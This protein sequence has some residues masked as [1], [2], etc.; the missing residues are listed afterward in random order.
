MEPF[1]SLK[2]PLSSR[3]SSRIQLD[4]GKLPI[5]EFSPYVIR[6]VGGRFPILDAGNFEALAVNLSAHL[7][8]MDLRST[9]IPGFDSCSKD[10]PSVLLRPRWERLAESG[11]MGTGSSV[12][13]LMQSL[14]A[15]FRAKQ[16]GD[17][18]VG[19]WGEV[20]VYGR[21]SHIRWASTVLWV[22]L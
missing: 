1:G 10:F 11:F 22:N 8:D 3:L 20:M 14:Q 15:N 7:P 18:W 5:D 19:K 13:M 12:K 4:A 21:W 17:G 9:S 6:A 16:Q 2:L